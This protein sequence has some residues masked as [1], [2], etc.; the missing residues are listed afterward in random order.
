ME[1]ILWEQGWIDPTLA[2]KVYTVYGTKDLMGAVRKDTSLQYLMTSLKDFETQE[3]MLCIKAR[4][5]GIMIGRTPKCHCE[6]AGE[7]IKYAWGCAKNHY[8]H[9]PLK[10]KR[11]KDNFGQTVRKCFAR[12]VVTTEQVRLFSQ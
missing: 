9:Q 11:G 2:R 8:R 7:G 10:H 1:Q 12:Q 4:E 5:T 3:T 6:L